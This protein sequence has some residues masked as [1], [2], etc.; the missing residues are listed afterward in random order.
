MG[1]DITS[2][3][4]TTSAIAA[5]ELFADYEQPV[6]WVF[7][8][9][10]FVAERT[11]NAFESNTSERNATPRRRPSCGYQTESRPSLFSWF[12]GTMAW[13][14]SSR[15]CMSDVRFLVELFHSH[16]V[17]SRRSLDDGP[18]GKWAGMRLAHL[19]SGTLNLEREPISVRS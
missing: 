2:Q 9:D 3:A 8:H 6:N 12:I 14:D 7:G 11:A 15:V 19:P 17:L 5:P 13:S 1:F 16:A 10:R 18:S 4:S